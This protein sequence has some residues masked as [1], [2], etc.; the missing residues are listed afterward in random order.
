[1]HLAI[2]DVVL[3]QL[4]NEIAEIV[5]TQLSHRYSYSWMSDGRINVFFFYDEGGLPLIS[6][7]EFEDRLFKVDLVVDARRYVAQVAFIHGRIHRVELKKPRKFFLGKEYRIGAVKAGKPSDSFT[8]V[9]DR[10]AH[11]KETEFNP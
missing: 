5:R 1:M 4:P 7:P 9:I 6:D 10:A 3:Q 11:G 8:G 2:I